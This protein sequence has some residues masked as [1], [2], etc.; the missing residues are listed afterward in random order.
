MSGEIKN[1][2]NKASKAKL[3]ISLV[4]IFL[5]LI[6]YLLVVMDDIFDWGIF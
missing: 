6:I 3:V 2:K 4:G 1:E 5:Y